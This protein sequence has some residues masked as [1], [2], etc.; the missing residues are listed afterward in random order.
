MLGIFLVDSDS[1]IW[2]QFKHHRGMQIIQ[3]YFEFQQGWLSPHWQRGKSLFTLARSDGLLFFQPWH[4]L[5][6]QHVSRGISWKCSHFL[7]ELLSPQTSSHPS[8]TA[9]CRTHAGASL[10]LAAMS[11]Q[12][13]GA[14]WIIPLSKRLLDQTVF[15]TV[16]WRAKSISPPWWAAFPIA[17]IQAALQCVCTPWV[18]SWLDQLD[19][20]I[21]KQ[22]PGTKMLGPKSQV[23]NASEARI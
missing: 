4:S 16:F 23:R 15:K 22:G 11:Q 7:V 6:T 19:D 14:T 21:E 3:R 10:C 8:C 2:S 5:H 18:L 13:T 9:H 17:S 20:K 1:S 12:K